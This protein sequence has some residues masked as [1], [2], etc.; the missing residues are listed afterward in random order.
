MLPGTDPPRLLFK[1]EG[2]TEC[3]I[4]PGLSQG[5]YSS[6]NSLDCRKLTNEEKESRGEL[7]L[8]TWPG[9]LSAVWLSQSCSCQLLLA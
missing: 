4:N 8:V 2:H 7:V 9:Q 6:M 1:A 3:W 5:S